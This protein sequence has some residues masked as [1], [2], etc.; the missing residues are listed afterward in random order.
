MEVTESQ[1]SEFAQVC[2]GDFAI[3][4]FEDGVFRIVEFARSLPAV[5]GMTLQEFAAITCDDAANLVFSSDRRAFNT[6]ARKAMKS[7]QDVDF[8][9]RAVHRQG[10]PIWVHANARSMGTKGGH[11]VFVAVFGNTSS[12]TAELAELL[13]HLGGIVYVID[14]KTHEILYANESALRM[15]GDEAF[16]GKKCYSFING[17]KRPCRWCPIPAMENGSAHISEFQNPVTGKWFQVNCHV[18]DWF[19]HEAIANSFVE[20]TEQKRRQQGIEFDR[21]SLSSIIENL[22]M[23][24]GVR[25]V[26][27]GKIVSSIMNAKMLQLLGIAS[28]EE[29][30]DDRAMLDGVLDA[31]RKDLIAQMEQMPH[32]GKVVSCAFRFSTA[33]GVPMRWYRLVS[34]TTGVPGNVMVFSCLTDVTDEMEAQAKAAE[35]QRMFNAVIDEARLVV[36]EYDIPEHRVIMSEGDFSRNDYKKFG[37]SRVIENAP[38]SLA[39]LIEDEDVPAFLEMYHKVAHG[40]AEASCEVWYK[41]TGDQQ[42]RC[43]HISYTTVFDESGNPVKAYGMG[44]NITAQK[45]EEEKYSRIRGGVLG[46]E[47]SAIYTMRLNLTANT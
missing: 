1:I 27:D 32:P 2:P 28:K 44:Q 45:L 14:R 8:T 6:S 33:H 47:A 39:P 7:S 4:T 25:E 20:I 18:I 38:E 37:L 5:L 30:M 3:F 13:D 17:F 35:A 31:D 34:R 19:G 9:F 12:E 21:D 29:G 15:W 16:Y 40:E 43:E 46:S 26:I 24:V 22:P 23:G 11:P 36:W 41:T 10:A 42:P